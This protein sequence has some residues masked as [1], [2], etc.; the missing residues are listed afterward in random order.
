MRKHWRY[1]IIIIL[2]INVL[3]DYTYTLHLGEIFGILITPNR[4][5]KLFPIIIFLLLLIYNPKKLLL[6]LPGLLIIGTTIISLANSSLGIGSVGQTLDVWLRYLSSLAFLFVAGKNLTEEDYIKIFNILIFISL[7]PIFISFLQYFEKYEFT[8]FDY[9]FGKRVGRV[10]GGYAKSVALIGVLYYGFAFSL[11]MFF[12][13]KS[14]FKKLN[15]LAYLTLT[16]IIILLTYHRAS[17]VVIFSV[18]IIIG[19]FYDKKILII[20]VTGILSLAIGYF[21]YEYLLEMYKTISMAGD[22]SFLRG[23]GGT[24]AFYLRDFFDSNIFDILF[25]KGNAVIKPSSTLMHHGKKIYNEPHNDI[26]RIMYQYGIVGVSLFI[27][28]LIGLI[29]KS[30]KFAIREKDP[31]HKI[32]GV[33]SYATGIAIM[34]YSITIEPTRY[35]VFYWYY[36]ALMS[37][38][39]VK[40]SHRPLNAIE[41]TY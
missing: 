22:S 12:A 19:W 15:Y 38:I 29:R 41:K 7:I 11:T 24:W 6:H 33:L 3:I 8:D 14:W 27:W 10:S 30:K 5:F 40:Q 25:G 36:T 13:S 23:R 16:T 37:F 34:L 1:I 28:F 21:A 18:M 17:I 20:C 26:L 4:I 2:S 31:K 9:L 35:P 32:I 39:I